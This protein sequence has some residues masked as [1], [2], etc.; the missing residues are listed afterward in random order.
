MID[1]IENQDA[2]IG[3][4]EGRYVLGGLPLGIGKGIWFPATPLFVE[5]TTPAG[6]HCRKIR[7][8]GIEY[9]Q[10]RDA[11][12]VPR[13][14]DDHCIRIRNDYVRY[15]CDTSEEV[16]NLVNARSAI[17][18]AMD[19]RGHLTDDEVRA[20]IFVIIRKV[21]EEG[22]RELQLALR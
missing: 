22:E 9:G 3:N 5:R 13:D 11:V 6:H 8:L 1:I 2:E 18:G 21:M 12:L 16:V 10:A 7:M 15:V 14:L 17:A 4:I 20:C 19:L